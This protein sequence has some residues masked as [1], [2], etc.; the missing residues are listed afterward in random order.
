MDYTAKWMSEAAKWFG[1]SADATFTLLEGCGEK[2]WAQKI[3][4]ALDEYSKNGNVEPYLAFFG[5]AG[6]LNDLIL[7]EAHGHKVSP[8]QYPWVNTLLQAL[9]SL[10]SAAAQALHA[11]D[12]FNLD[13]NW[14]EWHRKLQ[15]W[16]CIDCDHASLTPLEI[17]SALAAWTVADE[18]HPQVPEDC[19][20][21]VEIAI[22]GESTNVHQR[23]TA[24]KENAKLANISVSAAGR[25]K[26]LMR[27]CPKCGSE[28]TQAFRWI[29]EEDDATLTAADNALAR[30]GGRKKA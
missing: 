27:P 19:R 25:D 16:I 3:R 26:G 8:T 23:R 12:K 30:R 18:L 9:L 29:L 22:K 15:G 28:K 7:S 2:P 1:A 13:Q 20:Q 24:L 17:E 4:A 5:G 10:S 14:F 11:K 6:S 21:A